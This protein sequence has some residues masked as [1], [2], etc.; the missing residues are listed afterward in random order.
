MRGVDKLEVET[1]LA[2]AELAPQLAAAVAAH[3]FVPL[4]FLD[5]FVPFLLVLF[6]IDPFHC[7]ILL[8]VVVGR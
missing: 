7:P 4:S 6:P 1:D 5:E 8:V 2:V 3:S